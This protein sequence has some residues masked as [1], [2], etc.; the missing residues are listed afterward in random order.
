MLD[1][2]GEEAGNDATENLG[3]YEGDVVDAGLQGGGT[4]NGLEPDREVVDDIEE[5]AGEAEGE[6]GAESDG[7]VG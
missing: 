5:G 7:A 2:S 6:E 4:A 3:E 1:D